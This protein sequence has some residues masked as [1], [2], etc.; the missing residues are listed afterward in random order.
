MNT[1]QVIGLG[2]GDLD[3]LPLGV[4]K[5][6]KKATNLYV[7]TQ[8]HPVLIELAA[9]GVEFTSF[10]GVYEKHD[11]FAPVYAEIA[12]TLVAYS[13]D[14]SV[15]YAVPGHPLVA[16]QT[17]QNLIEAEKAGACHLSIEGGHSFLDALFGALRIDPIEGFQLLDGTEMKS[18]DVN[19]TQHIL[20]AQ[21]YDSFSASEVKLTLMEK[22]PEDYP[23]T[24]VTAAGSADEILRTVPLYELDRAA[25]VNNLTTV[26]VPPAKD[27]LTRLKEWQTF[28][29]IVA[30]LRSPEGCPWDREQTHESLRPYLLEEAHEL[31]QAIEEQDDE[32]I[33]E[34][35]GDVLLQVFLHAQIGQDNGYFQLED[36]LSA[37]S[38]KMIRRHPHVFGDAKVKDADEVV[39]N[40]QAIKAQEKPAVESILDGQERFS[41]SLITSYNYQKKAA[42]VGFSWSDAEGAWEKFEEELQ[43]FQ[44][45]LAKGSKDR[46]LDELGDLLFTLV[47][48][49]RFYELSPEEAMVHANRKFQ[50][51]FRHV[52]KRVQEGT[53]DFSDYSLD[54][55]DQFW[56]EAKAMARKED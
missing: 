21:V 26:Y 29:S 3:Q 50:Q 20:I 55:L 39:A 6:L 49:A 10:D 30:Q 13:K 2:A 38:S 46:Q 47:N 27:Q 17:V 8:D 54:Q 52:E 4:Y 24:I 41:S 53:G 11:T 5:K 42:K 51:R 19:M 35:L 28:R 34:E 1:I 45:E 44:A 40:W 12:D 14:Q 36:V 33:A 32:A 18:D 43:E 7:R 56:N 15:T 22:Y 23:V 37:V 31:I 25:E 48:I 16:E 9:E